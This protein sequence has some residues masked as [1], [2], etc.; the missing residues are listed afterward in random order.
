MNRKICRQICLFVTLAFLFVF[1]SQADQASAQVDLQLNL[2]GDLAG[3]PYRIVVPSNWNGTLLL[4]ARGT[5]SIAIVDE[6]GQLIT[7]GV[8]P[9]TNVP[10]VVD[11]QGLPDNGPALQLEQTL[12]G[13]GYALAAS[14]YS[15][16]LFRE[17]GLLGWVVKAGIKDTLALT[18]LFKSMVG[19]PART[20]LWSRSQGTLVALKSIERFPAKSRIYDG[21]IAGCA[22]G[23]GANRSWDSAVDFSLAYDVAFKDDGGWLWGTVGDVD[24]NVV[25]GGIDDSGMWFGDVFPTLLSQ[26]S[27]PTNLGRFEFIRLVSKLPVEGFYPFHGIPNLDP[28]FSWLFAD[29][30]FATE[31]R[32]DVERKAH[33]HVGQNLDHFYALT[34]LEKV[35]LENL[36]VDADQ[37][38]DEM[39][40]R[41]N[42]EASRQ[43]TSYLRRYAD[44]SGKIS[45]RVLTMHT[46]I[47][48]L[49]LPAQQTVYR[50]TVEAANTSEKLV[51]VFVNSVGHCTFTPEQ[52]LA[53][54]E[55]MDYW[56]ATGERPGGEFFEEGDGFVSFDPGPYPQPPQEP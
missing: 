51:Q 10:G 9:L 42:I 11:E 20:I 25:F 12:L 38:L 24:N 19:Q 55:A 34:D 54:V 23:A 37:L 39:N 18:A 40:M 16:P 29:M 46:T 28:S 35:Y 31:V 49:V 43:G 6:N 47:D 13:M 30:L 5:G 56:L 17:T 2:V 8:T 41:T 4:Y 22:L 45:A 15:D 26:V 36:G 48:G 27:V 14:D 52:W 50:E 21:V 53:T 7:L 33:G 3:A 44:F 1:W 32:A